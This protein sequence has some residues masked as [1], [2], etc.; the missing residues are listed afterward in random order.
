VLFYLALK[1]SLAKEEC[2]AMM[3]GLGQKLDTTC[4]DKSFEAFE[5]VRR[6]FAGLFDKY[7]GDTE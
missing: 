6:P 3:V 4:L 2:K 5:Y 1:F 7:T